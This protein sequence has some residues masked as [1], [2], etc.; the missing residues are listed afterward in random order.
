MLRH[1]QIEDELVHI[2]AMISLLEQ[3]RNEDRVGGSNTRVLQPEYWR[4]RVDAVLAASEIP[5]WL[6]ERALLLVV[7]L[8]NLTIDD[9]SA[10]KVSDNNYTNKKHSNQ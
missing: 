8:D 6:T 1:T 3:H 2:Q 10:K 5:K 9:R 7:R 4:M